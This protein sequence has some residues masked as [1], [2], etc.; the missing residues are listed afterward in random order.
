[1]HGN[2]RVE[3]T[4]CRCG[5]H[6]KV[7]FGTGFLYPDH[8]EVISDI[9]YG[10]YGQH[11]KEVYEGIPGAVVNDDF[12]L[13]VCPWCRNYQ[14]EINLSLYEP[15]KKEELSPELKMPFLQVLK[16]Y[17]KPD[18]LLSL[19]REGWYWGY[20]QKPYVHRCGEC[21]RRMHL[22]NKYDLLRCPECKVGTMEE[23]DWWF[24]D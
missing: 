19:K 3:L 12:E 2:E 17:K 22:Y 15:R 1:M 4:C 6:E 18:R 14:N 7:L 10:R 20:W 21:G 5:Y 11:W 16:S 24:W 8:Q 23:T 13:Y 9:T